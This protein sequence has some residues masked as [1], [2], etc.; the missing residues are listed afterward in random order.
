MSVDPFAYAQREHEKRSR[1]WHNCCAMFTRMAFG[2]PAIGDF[3]GDGVADAEDVWKAAKKKHP[4]SNPG[5]IPRGVPVF[6]S[7]GSSDNGHAAVSRG[8]GT[9]WTT[10]LVRDGYV[11]VANIADVKRKWGLTL[12]GWTE[13]I[14]GITV[15]KPGSNVPKEESNMANLD[16]IEDMCE[17]LI[18]SNTRIEAVLSVLKKDHPAE[19]DAALKQANETNANR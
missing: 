13:D 12:L 16:H 10:D 15:Y 14:N 6:W 1:N 18:Y 11:D 8:Q 4:T 3:D 19:Y 9:M 7:G 5:E 17:R 2:A